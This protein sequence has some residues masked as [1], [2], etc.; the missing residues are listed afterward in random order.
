MLRK[1]HI[2]WNE[3]KTQGVIFVDDPRQNLEEWP[4]TASDDA[5]QALTGNSMQPCLGSA[6][7]ERWLECYEEDTEDGKTSLQVVPYE[8]L[9]ASGE[10]PK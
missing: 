3:D 10:W 7:A 1:A 4:L 2:V 5:Y 8:S 9:I 6:L